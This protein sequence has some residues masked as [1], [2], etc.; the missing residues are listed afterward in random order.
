LPWL[1]TA[2]GKR[3]LCSKTFIDS[4][5]SGAATSHGN[6]PDADSTVSVTRE[7]SVPVVRPA[8]REARN[9]EG[10]LGGR[11]RRKVI[12]GELC[13]DQ[14]ALKIPDL[15][16]KGS[17]GAQP[18]AVGGEAQ[19]VDGVS[20]I[21]RVKVLALLEIPQHGSVVLSTRRAERAIGRNGHAGEVARVA[22]KVGLQ[23]AGG[24]VPHLD[25]L[26]PAAGH[27]QSVLEG[28]GEAHAR[29]PLGVTLF[30]GGG[31]GNGVLELAD[32]V[33]ELDGL[34]ARAGD[35]LAVV[36]GE[37]HREHVLRVANELAS[38][39]LA[40]EVPQTHG[41][42]PG[43][44]QSIVAIGGDNY[45]LD[46]VGVAAKRLAGKAIAALGAVE[47]PHKKGLVARGGH[48]HV[49][50]IGGGDRCGRNGGNPAIVGLQRAAWRESLGHFCLFGFA[51]DNPIKSLLKRWSLRE[52]KR[53]RFR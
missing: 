22:N 29:H 40:V 16:G 50:G 34:V 35:D 31:G 48:D 28:G 47:V 4:A 25:E 49:L 14:L 38:G 18:I 33:P 7:E 36:G 20:S 42:V 12:R 26:V 27:D 3:T 44:R 11:R 51:R 37:G 39:M 30:G 10:L 21:K 45:V 52:L 53:W 46:E 2:S 5:R 15:D 8:E 19:G 13:H 9:G 23:L 6:S 1:F 32:S 24:E 41:P 17:S 43:A